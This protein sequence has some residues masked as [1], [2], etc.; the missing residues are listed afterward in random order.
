ARPRLSPPPPRPTPPPPPPRARPG[1]G[2]PHALRVP[3]PPRLQRRDVFP[4]VGDVDR[5]RHDV[6][7]RGPGL[8]HHRRDVG[9]RLPQLLGEAGAHQHAALVPA[10]LSRDGDDL[11]ALDHAVGVP[12]RARPP[13]RLH[14][15]PR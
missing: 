1:K 3:P 10:D 6:L 13:R 11:A 15:A 5:E 7:R 14:P 8:A 9:E 2:A 12:P 4:P